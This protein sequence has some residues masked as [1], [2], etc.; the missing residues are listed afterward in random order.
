MVAMARNWLA[1]AELPS[2]FWF[3]AVNH[4][5][6]VCNYF[7]FL[8]EDG[9]YTTPFELAYNTKPDLRVLFKLFGLVVVCRERVGDEKLNK[10]ESQSIPLI[11]IG[12]CPNSNGLMFYNPSTGSVVSSIDYVFQPN[13]TS[14]ARFGYR[15]QSGTFI[16][17][18]DESNA[19][20]EP[21]FLL[22]SKVLVHT[23]SP[24][25]IAAVVGLP[26]YS[27]PD[28]YTVYF[29]DGSLAEYSVNDDLLEAS[30]IPTT[31]PSTNSLLPYWVKGGSNATL[32]LHTMTK[33]CHGKMFQNLDLEWVFC[34]GVSTDVSKSIPL[35]DLLSSFQSFL[36]S[37][38]LFQGH[39]KFCRVYQTR[40]QI[41][42]WDC[43]LR[44]VTAHG[45]SSFVAPS[46]LKNIASMSS[47]DQEIWLS[48]YVEEFDGLSSLPTWDIVTEDQFK[49]LSKGIKAL[50]SM[51]IATT[52]Y[53]EFNHP[54]RAKYRI[55]VLGNLDYHNW[56][57]EATA[58]PVMSQL[59]LQILTALAISQKQVLKNC[60]IKQ[61]FVQSSLPPEEV[62]FVKPP[63]GCPRSKPGTY[64]RLL[65]SLYGLKRAPRLWFEKLSSHLHFPLS[66]CWFSHWHI[67][68]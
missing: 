1:S 54:K 63:V 59:E 28:I 12:R 61:A 11:A 62:Y 4:A 57:K 38:Q 22:D 65:R 68:G 13:V 31:S 58:A 67:C 50:P 27:R 14:G 42:L 6:E 40:T 49:R 15:Y 18:L 43:V 9:T 36:D 34:S 10:F 51:A 17:R 55:V 32:F 37:G 48:A 21:K 45:L 66:V 2:T 44:H 47:N 8:L 30:S 25:H 26:T 41:Q 39:T 20:F 19:I 64:W 3:Y 35:P 53:D 60:D 7:P 23:H 46:S 33:P 24:P 5:A 16:Y 56:S 52:K 29:Q